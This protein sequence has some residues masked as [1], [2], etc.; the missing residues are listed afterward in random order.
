MPH[1]LAVLAVAALGAVALALP[2]DPTIT[3]A[4][5]SLTGKRL[6]SAGLREGVQSRD[7]A[8]FWGIPF[9][10]PPVGKLRFKPPKPRDLPESQFDATNEHN[11]ACIQQHRT[12]L[13]VTGE[14]DCLNLQVFTPSYDVANLPVVVLIHGGGFMFSQGPRS[15]VQYIMDYDVVLV[16]IAYRLNVLGFMSFE[17]PELQGNLGML[18]QVEALKWVQRNVHHFGGDKDSVTLVGNSAGCASC[19]LHTMSPMSKGLFHRVIGTSGTPLNPW[20]Q[21]HS[22]RENADRVA[23]LVGCNASTTA[24]K[25]ACLQTKPAAEIVGLQAENFQPWMLNP[26]AP[27]STVVDGLFLTGEPEKVLEDKNA[28]M[29]VPLML[30]FVPLEGLFPGGEFFFNDSLV[31]ELDEH[32][33]TTAPELL[34]F[35]DK[36]VLEAEKPTLSRKIREFYLKNLSLESG[37]EQLMKLMTDRNFLSGVSSHISRRASVQSQ[38]VYAFEFAHRGEYSYYGGG[39]GVGHGDDMLYPLDLLGPFHREDDQ[40]V[41]RNLL[42]LWFSFIKTSKPSVPGVV[43]EPVQPNNAEPS[44]NYLRIAGPNDMTMTTAKNLGNVAFWKDWKD[45][46]P[47]HSER[48][49]SSLALLVSVG[50]LILG[51][52]LTS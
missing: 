36:R 8:A 28:V 29:D 21:Q 47:N 32:W 7:Y 52:A 43:W 49:Q 12:S 14:E 23:S 20:A 34:N 4:R 11:P 9:A 31:R 39:L 37:K 44:V 24:D 30:G 6:Q 27:F 40:V 18:D 3:H 13:R 33:D 22:A 46:Q 51:M 5:G 19:L 1:L 45:I 38:P 25:V 10:E 41:R 2:E 15:G 50:V 17:D 35:H 16:V 42:D 26:F 48:A